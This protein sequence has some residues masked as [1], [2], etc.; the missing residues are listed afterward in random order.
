MIIVASLL[1]DS[2]C[3]QVDADVAAGHAA[4]EQMLFYFSKSSCRQKQHFCF[5]E[6]IFTLKVCFLLLYAQ[7]NSDCVLGSECY[8]HRGDSQFSRVPASCIDTDGLKLLLLLLCGLCVGGGFVSR[9]RV[10]FGP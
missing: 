9:S 5:V 2:R 1:I 4:Q 6:H 8:Q 3:G 10:L 7:K